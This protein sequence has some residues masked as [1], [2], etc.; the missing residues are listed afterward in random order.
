MFVNGDRR[1]GHI[2]LVATSLRVGS[3]QLGW[4]E[5]GEV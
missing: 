2:A 1:R 4:L 3:A 5:I